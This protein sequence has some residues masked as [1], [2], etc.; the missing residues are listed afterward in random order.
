MTWLFYMKGDVPTNR[1]EIYKECAIL[2]FEKWD[3]RRGIVAPIPTDFD[4]LH[5]FSQLASKIYGESTLEDG[6]SKEWLREEVERYFRVQYEDRER[7]SKTAKSLVDFI[8]GRAWVM[9]EVGENVFRFTHRTFLEY[10]FARHLDELH[11]SVGSL[12]DFLRGRIVKGERDVVS[13]LALQLKTYRHPRRIAE[14][15]EGLRSL[16]RAGVQRG[17][18]EGLAAVTFAAAGSEYLPGAEDDVRVFVSDIYKASMGSVSSRLEQALQALKLVCRCARE[19]RDLSRRTISELL[20]WSIEHG[21]KREQRF[22]CAALSGGRRGGYWLP[23]EVRERTLA[24][25]KGRVWEYAER[26]P[27]FASLYWNWYGEGLEK[28]FRVHGL[29]MLLN[30]S[31][32]GVTRDPFSWRRSLWG[33]LFGIWIGDEADRGREDLRIIGANFVGAPVVERISVE[34]A[35]E[36]MI[37]APRGVWTRRLADATKLT[38]DEIWGIIYCFLAITE[39]NQMRDQAR[40]VPRGSLID[41]RTLPSFEKLVKEAVT[42][43]GES[44]ERSVFLNEWLEGKRRLIQCVPSIRQGSLL[45]SG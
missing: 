35:A 34:L 27:E 21:D 11:D 23:E 20:T 33:V 28:L 36:N 41:F 42:R 7:A 38:T 9:S 25:V 26:D 12:L 24:S 37:H 22:A 10:F 19:R 17:G 13:H 4:M 15:I 6:V 1:P 32:V 43:D 16:I 18:R 40:R 14:A 3:Q 5:L 29:G 44:S 8:G 45:N 30:E 2:M 31:Q 39:V